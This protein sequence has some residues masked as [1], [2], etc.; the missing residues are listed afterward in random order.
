MT[1][2][3]DNVSGHHYVPLHA[4]CF[5]GIITYL[6]LTTKSSSYYYFPHLS[7]KETEG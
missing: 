7:D 5:T 2:T 3:A 6:I 1:T 4:M